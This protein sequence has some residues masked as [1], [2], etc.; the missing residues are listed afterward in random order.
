MSPGRL[1]DCSCCLVWEWDV[2]GSWESCLECRCES[3]EPRRIGA[4]GEGRRDEPWCHAHGRRA[5][6]PHEP[7]GGTASARASRVQ[8]QWSRCDGDLPYGLGRTRRS[9]AAEAQ[10]VR[11]GH[12]GA[13]LGCA[14]AFHA[15]RAGLGH[16]QGSYRLQR[17]QRTGGPSDGRVSRSASCA[18]AL[19]GTQDNC[20]RPC[21]GV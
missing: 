20:G 17:E 8:R 7:V 14:R 3:S 11:A 4:C 12:R 5:R 13:R 1:G 6:P 15:G 9:A 10:S 2:V 19:Q 18:T 21:R 16:R